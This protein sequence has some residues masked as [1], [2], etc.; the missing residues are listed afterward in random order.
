MK[1]RTFKLIKKLI[2][3]LLYLIFLVTMIVCFIKFV[4]ADDV[5][6]KVDYGFWC[7][8]LLIVTSKEW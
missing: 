7:V 8:I 2:E 3:I 6:D 1:R 5:F 4:N